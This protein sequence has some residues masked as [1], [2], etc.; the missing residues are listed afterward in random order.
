VFAAVP[1]GQAALRPPKLHEDTPSARGRTSVF[2]WTFGQ[3]SA[4]FHHAS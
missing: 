4:D 2:D 3:L 1:G